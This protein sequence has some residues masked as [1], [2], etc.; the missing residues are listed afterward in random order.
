MLQLCYGRAC[1]LY[2]HSNDITAYTS[3][4]RKGY[5]RLL[6][7]NK[8]SRGTN[9]KPNLYE[10]SHLEIRA[11]ALFDACNESNQLEI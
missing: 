2:V 7:E 9:Y 3:P 11:I 1:V 8:K 10:T 4:F 6:L 5:T